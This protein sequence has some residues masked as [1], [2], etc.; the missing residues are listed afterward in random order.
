MCDRARF[1]FV[2]AIALGGVRCVGYTSGIEVAV[3]LQPSRPTVGDGIDEAV[4]IVSAVE[5]LPCGWSLADLYSVAHAHSDPSA[6]GS[7]RIDARHELG[8]QFLDVLTPAPGLYCGVRLHFDGEPAAW[9]A[10]DARRETHGATDV[11]IALHPLDL[12]EPGLT[13]VK[14]DFDPVRWRDAG[15][16]AA[17]S[18]A[19]FSADAS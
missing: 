18:A 13:S 6:P 3:V 5:L 1:V 12:S 7:L 19:A 9:L 16:A 11:D 2:L 8:A 15:F 4:V 14:V 10:A 17:F